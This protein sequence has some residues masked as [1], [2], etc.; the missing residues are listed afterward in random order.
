LFCSFEL[1]PR[2]CFSCNELI[3]LFD[4][5]LLREVGATTKGLYFLGLLFVLGCEFGK[6]GL[7]RFVRI[8]NVAVLL[9][10]VLNL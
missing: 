5:V 3:P 7:E 6:I 9:L 4:P 2:E 1:V 8:L 10:E